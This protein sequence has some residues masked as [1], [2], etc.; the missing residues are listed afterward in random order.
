M[1]DAWIVD[2]VATLPEFRRTGMVD[3]LLSAILDKGRSHGF[4]RS[5]INIYIGNTPAQKAY[6]KH[7][8]TLVDEKRHP[9]FEAEIGS[10]GMARML[11]DL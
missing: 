6:E 5:Q 11:R 1:E 8:F 10:P 7:G 4:R 3:H 9:D 2:S